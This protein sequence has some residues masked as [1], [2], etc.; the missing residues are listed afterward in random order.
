MFWSRDVHNREQMGTVLYLLTG[1]IKITLSIL[2][3]NL[4]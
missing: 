4:H 1:V 3:I 2:F